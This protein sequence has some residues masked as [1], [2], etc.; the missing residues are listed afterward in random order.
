MAKLSWNFQTVFS[1]HAGKIRKVLLDVTKQ[2]DPQLKA[3]AA[4]NAE[5][6]NLSQ[7]SFTNI[8]SQPWG[9]GGC[10]SWNQN[11]TQ[12][13]EVQTS[14]FSPVQ[15]SLT[16]TVKCI[17]DVLISVI[18]IVVLTHRAKKISVM[19]RFD[20]PIRSVNYIQTSQLW[21]YFPLGDFWQMQHVTNWNLCNVSFI[22]YVLPCIKCI[23]VFT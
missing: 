11:K 16:R 4:S 9:Q 15:T 19:F 17:S 5:I 10:W 2:P 7:C 18:L 1:F 6:S 3:D 13:F 20:L 21:G 8:S 12:K 23:K 14:D 22:K